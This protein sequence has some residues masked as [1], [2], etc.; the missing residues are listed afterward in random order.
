M[1]VID[2]QVAR[3]WLADVGVEVQARV[4]SPPPGGTLTKPN[5]VRVARTGTRG[6]LVAVDELAAGTSRDISN[7]TL[8][9]RASISPGGL[10]DVPAYLYAP[11]RQ[12]VTSG[13]QFL[14]AERRAWKFM[15]DAAHCFS[16][17]GRMAVEVAGGGGKIDR[18]LCPPALI[19]LQ[20]AFCW[21]VPVF[22]KFGHDIY[23]FPV[24]PRTRGIRNRRNDRG[25]DRVL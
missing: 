12:G 7:D 2:V 6:S 3:G 25:E 17:S 18:A 21:A 11:L 14:A 15:R 19:T 22:V 8:G 10:L 5:R 9:L 23:R 20:Q 16:P 1:K 13:Y 4:T 24:E